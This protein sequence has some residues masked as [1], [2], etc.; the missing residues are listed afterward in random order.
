MKEKINWQQELII[1]E[2]F[3]DKFSKN[4]LE[5]F[6][7]NCVQGKYLGYMYSRWRKIRG[8]D[9]DDPIENTEQM[10]LLFNDSKKKIQ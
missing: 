1:S 2:R 4:L 10:P 3:N 6:A 9:K 8:L 7:K 5:H